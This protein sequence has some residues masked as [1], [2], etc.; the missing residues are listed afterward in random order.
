MHAISAKGVAHCSSIPDLRKL[1]TGQH[2]EAEQLMT[3]G[4]DCGRLPSAAGCGYLGDEKAEAG[5]GTSH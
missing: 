2:V 1:I 4:G 3:T 5:E